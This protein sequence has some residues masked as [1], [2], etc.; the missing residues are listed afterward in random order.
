M[1]IPAIEWTMT[2]DFI[3]F[4]QLENVLVAI[5]DLLFG[6]STVVW[7]IYQ[8]IPNLDYIITVVDVAISKRI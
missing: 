2:Q 3:A 1:E 7:Q 5:E 6:E 4:F 8:I